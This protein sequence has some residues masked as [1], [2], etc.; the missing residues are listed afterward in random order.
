MWSRYL[1]PS[2]PHQCGGGGGGPAGEAG[3]AI[4]GKGGEG[5]SNGGR[6]GSGEGGGGGRLAPLELHIATAGHASIARRARGGLYAVHTT[7]NYK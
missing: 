6:G 7:Y 5:G 4:G 2:K 3:G 1:R